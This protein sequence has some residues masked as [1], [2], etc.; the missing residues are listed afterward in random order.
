MIPITITEFVKQKVES[1]PDTDAETLIANCKETLKAKHCGAACI[2]C[3]SPIWAAGSA[4]TGTYMCFT[5]MTGEIDDSE[6]Y[7]IE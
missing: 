6:D 3:N 7:E 5:C 4:I 2:I 1:N